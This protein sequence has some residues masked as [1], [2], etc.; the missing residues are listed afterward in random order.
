MKIFRSEAALLDDSMRRQLLDLFIVRM[1]ERREL[2][3]PMSFEILCNMCPDEP[4]RLAML[5]ALMDLLDSRILI[6]AENG[7]LTLVRP[8]EAQ[9]QAGLFTEDTLD[10]V[11]P[12]T[13]VFSLADDVQRMVE[14]KGVDEACREIAAAQASKLN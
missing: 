10:L 11:P 14:E 9:I 7:L 4:S 13:Q 6:E 1:L 12:G 3:D 8:C 2:T 5:D